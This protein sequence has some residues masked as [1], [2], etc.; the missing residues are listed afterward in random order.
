MIDLVGPGIDPP[1]GIDHAR[2][3]IDLGWQR[4]EPFCARLDSGAFQYQ[5]WV[6]SK[7]PN[8]QPN[9]FKPS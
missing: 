9:N 7:P 4:I 6:V 2:A 3:R 8:I 1:I 5:F